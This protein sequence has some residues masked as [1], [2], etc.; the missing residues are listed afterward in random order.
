MFLHSALGSSSELEYFVLLARD[1]ELLSSKVH[2]QLTAE[3]REVKRM[4]T[5]LVARLRAD[6]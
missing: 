3:I 6:G 4:L 2:D 1:L 5:A